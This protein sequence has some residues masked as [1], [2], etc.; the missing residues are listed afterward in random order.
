MNKD[1]L[2]QKIKKVSADAA[3]S[4]IDSIKTKA[5]IKKVGAIYIDQHNKLFSVDP[6]LSKGGHLVT[7]AS[8]ALLTGGLTLVGEAASKGIKNATRQWIPFEQL[9]D[10][11]YIVNNERVR[12]SEGGRVRLAKGFYVGGTSS[13]SK[14]VTSSSYF[15][16]TLNNLDNPYIKIPIINK[17]LKGKDF[18]EAVKFGKE[19]EVA[20]NFI[21]EN[22]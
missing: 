13:T 21:L 19:T 12:V 8:L 2:F 17:P 16:L 3:A 10:Y 9:R 7:K 15:E 5:A 14:S 1:D 22:K 6:N 20:L 4:T 11:D 18:D